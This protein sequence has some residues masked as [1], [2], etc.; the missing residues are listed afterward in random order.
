MMTGG[1]MP[2]SGIMVADFSRV[3]A[4]PLAATT[5]ADLGATVIKV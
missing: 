4:G 3:L 5:L 2:L 1:A